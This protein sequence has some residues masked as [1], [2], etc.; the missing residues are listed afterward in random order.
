[1]RKSGWPKVA[2]RRLTGTKDEG[3]FINGPENWTLEAKDEVTHR[4]PQYLR[5]AALEAA[6][7]GTRW[8]AAVVKARNAPTGDAFF[9]MPWSEGKELMAHVERL[10]KDV[11]L[12]YRLFPHLSDTATAEAIEQ[13]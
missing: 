1:M 2:R 13:P 9:V 7:A 10:E 12:F 3:D 6:H 5:E 11:A 8:F 4:I